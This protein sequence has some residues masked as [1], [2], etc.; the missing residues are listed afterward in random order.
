M[1]M[2]ITISIWTALPAALLIAGACALAI[3]ASRQPDQTTALIAGLTDGQNGEDGC[4][5]IRPRD[6]KQQGPGEA[7]EHL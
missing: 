3:W 2:L 5:T 4:A 6:P 1:T 7:H